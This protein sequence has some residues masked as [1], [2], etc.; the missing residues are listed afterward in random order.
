MR[1]LL[2]NVNILYIKN[3]FW[4]F[5]Y[6]P[7]VV[8]YE[9]GA[10]NTATVCL[11][12]SAD[13][14]Y[15]VRINLCF[16]IHNQGSF[17]KLHWFCLF[18]IATSAEHRHKNVRN[19]PSKFT[20]RTYNI[21][22]DSGLSL[23]QRQGIIWTNN[24]LLSL[25]ALGTNFNEILIE[26]YMFSFKQNALKMS[27]GN[28][29]PFC[30]GLD[31]LM[32]VPT[33][34]T[35]NH[36]INLLWAQLFVGNNPFR[37]VMTIWKAVFSCQTATMLA[38]IAPSDCITCQPLWTQSLFSSQH[39]RSV[40]AVCRHCQQYNTKHYRINLWHFYTYHIN[41][42]VCITLVKFFFPGRD[43]DLA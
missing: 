18:D 43:R 2:W 7:K 9:V 19:F 20:L 12:L 36:H 24:G 5:N 27:P 11:S 33:K 38:N 10:R 23:D 21:G 25:R 16:P 8:W 42:F 14:S 31:L 15:S 34:D 22:W 4:S 29:R 13:I 37:H 35:G 28:L 30:L 17:E 1:N 41:V 40:D 39:R 32:H 26:N 3:R 6:T